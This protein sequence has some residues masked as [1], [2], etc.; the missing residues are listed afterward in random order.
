MCKNDFNIRKYV[1]YKYLHVH[2]DAHVYTQS[3][4]S[5]LKKNTK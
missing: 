4:T 1:G 3:V 2:M 5:K